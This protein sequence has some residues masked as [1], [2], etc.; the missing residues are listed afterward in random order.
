M[1]KILTAFI[2]SALFIGPSFALAHVSPNV[3]LVTTKEAVSQL[4]PSGKLFLKQVHL[5]NSQM[6]KLQSN[7][8]WNSH[9]ANYKF[10]VSRDKNN[11]IQ[12]VAIFITEFTRHGPI[13]VAVSLDSTGKVMDAMVTD[14]QMETLEWVG[15]LIRN[16][17]FQEFRGKGSEFSL[18]LQSK[19]L[20]QSSSITR[21]FAH[22]LANAVKRSTQLYQLAF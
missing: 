16:G 11:S 21:S 14:I 8:N 10:F 15:P 17:F 12:R 1:K 4:L 18:D 19:S 6:Q 22:I 13:V 2:I 9:E 7:D 5:N 3:K 20:A